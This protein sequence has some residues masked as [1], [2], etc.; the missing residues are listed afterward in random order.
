MRKSWLARVLFC[1]MLELGAL[2]GAPVRP[3]EIE[4]LM[5]AAD[6]PGVVQ[7]LRRESDGDGDP[8]RGSEPGGAPSASAARRA[9]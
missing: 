4:A 8:P 5:Q 6:R 3:E 9:P 1:L 2:S 7:V